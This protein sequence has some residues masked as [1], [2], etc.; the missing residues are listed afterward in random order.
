MNLNFDNR[1]RVFEKVCRRV[2]IKHFNPAMNGVE[3]MRWLRAK[4]IRSWPVTSRRRLLKKSIDTGMRN[5][6]ARHPIRLYTASAQMETIDGFSMS[7]KAVRRT[8]PACPAICCSNVVGRESSARRLAFLPRRIG[9]SAGGEASWRPAEHQS[10]VADA[11]ASK[12]PITAPDP[13]QAEAELRDSHCCLSGLAS[14]M[15]ENNGIAPKVSVELS[16]DGL[17]DGRDMQLQQTIVDK[18]LYL[19]S[20]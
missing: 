7:V 5:I 2:E 20:L 12:A 1:A 11:E 13:V 14:R 8:P 19:I 18:R 6:L 16:R 10:S 4:R 3:R 9:G 17:G 15:L